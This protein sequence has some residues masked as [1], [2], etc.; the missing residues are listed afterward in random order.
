MSQLNKRFFQRERGTPQGDVTSPHNWTSFFDIALRALELD[1][2][3][4]ASPAHIH[5]THPPIR[6]AGTRVSELAYAD[7]LVS[8]AHT[9]E[10]L[11]RKA[12]IISAFTILFDMEISVG[13]LRLAVFGTTPPSAAGPAHDDTLLIHKAGW[14]PEAVRFRRT[15][16]IKMLG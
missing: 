9:R 14:T 2:T 6:L 5:A 11:Q 10:G 4:P 16:T 3:D 1:A 7:D 13:K 12:D 8:M 15:G